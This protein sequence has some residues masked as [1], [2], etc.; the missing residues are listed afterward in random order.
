MNLLGNISGSTGTG[1]G[2]GGN[3][4]HINLHHSLRDVFL[5]SIIDD[6]FDLLSYSPLALTR[7]S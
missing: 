4:S 5:Y 7:A 3:S 2:G 6:K 1:A